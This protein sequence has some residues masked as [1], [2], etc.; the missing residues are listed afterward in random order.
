M[1]DIDRSF[2]LLRMANPH[3]T[4][5]VE[6]KPTADEMLRRV[7]ERPAPAPPV[8]APRPQWRRGLVLAA[9]AFVVVLALLA[10]A[11]LFNEGDE[12]PVTEPPTTTTAAPTTRRRLAG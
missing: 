11:L 9:A 2:E 3:S 12:P 10:P 6:D 5:V 1:V 8:R 4:V 7:Q